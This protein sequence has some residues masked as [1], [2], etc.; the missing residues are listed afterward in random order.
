[1]YRKH[2]VVYIYM[3]RCFLEP[4]VSSP[5]P[6]L[7]R[8]YRSFVRLNLE[9]S[10]GWAER[11]KGCA[12]VKLGIYIQLSKADGRI[13]W[14]CYRSRQ[15]FLLSNATHTHTQTVTENPGTNGYL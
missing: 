12:Y 9:Y 6:T 1:M 15:M 4:R 5:L 11:E 10:P 3:P 14:D 8:H 7:K 2:I 13:W